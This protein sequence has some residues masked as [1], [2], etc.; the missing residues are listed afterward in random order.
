MAYVSSVN[1]VGNPQGGSGYQNLPGSSAASTPTAANTLGTAGLGVAGANTGTALANTYNNT[2]PV[3]TSLNTQYQ[4]SLA[5]TQQGGSTQQGDVYNQGQSQLQ[6]ELS[7]YYN[8]MLAGNVPTSFTEPQAPFTALYNNFVTQTAP[9]LANQYGAGSP[10]I[11]SQLA[12]QDSNL[13][14][15]LY[16]QGITNYLNTLGSATNNAYTAIG[17]NQNQQAGTNAY[18]LGYGTT[19]SQNNL[20]TSAFNSSYGISPNYTPATQTTQTT[21]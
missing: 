12:L 20:N 19:N 4:G 2:T 10:I 1:P 7:P 5:G 14:A 11:N 17:A 9:T 16:E 15:N 6:N 13:A 18:D 3:T 8:N 21:Q